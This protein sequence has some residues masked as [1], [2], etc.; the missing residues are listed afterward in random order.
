MTARNPPKETSPRP[1]SVLIVQRRLTEYRVALFERLK[2]LLAE[3]GLQLL[4]VHGTATHEE[5][6][7]GDAGVLPWAVRVP[8]V[9]LPLFGNRLSWLRIPGSIFQGQDLVIVTH[10]NGILS[11][12]LPFLRRSLGGPRVAWWG[13]G[14]KW[15]GAHSFGRE[16]LKGCSALIGDRY[17]AYTSASV[18]RVTAA[19]V[20][21]DRI[22]CL[23]NAVGIEQHPLPGDTAWA[24]DREQLKRELGLG[25]G[26]VGIYLGSLTREKRIDVLIDA[27]DELRLRHPTFQ[28]IIVGDGS[29]RKQVKMAQANR[30]WLHWLGVLHGRRKALACSLGHA[31]LNPGMVGLSIVDA[32][33]AGLPLVTMQH[34][35]HSPEIAYLEHGKNGLLAEDDLASFVAACERALTDESLRTALLEGCRAGALRY[36]VQRMADLFADGITATVGGHSGVS[37]QCFPRLTLAVVFRTFLPYHKARLRHL[38]ST[39]RAAGIRLLQIEVASQDS[40]YDFTET[41]LGDS[42]ERYCCFPGIDYQ[43]L[44]A[45]NVHGKVLEL[46][47]QL[48]PDAVIGHAVPFP[49]GMAAIA[50]RNRTGARVF[51]VDDAWSGSDLSGPIVRYVKRFIHANVDGALLPSKTHQD[52]YAELGLGPD[53]TAVGAAVVDNAF[54]DRNASAARANPVS[55]RARLGMPEHYFL[56]VGRFLERKGITYL[57]RAYGRYRANAERPWSLVLVG[58]SGL[59]LPEDACLQPGVMMPGRLFGDDLAMTIG[60]AGALVVPS[61]I[62]QWGL[63]VNEAMAAGTPVIVSRACGAAQLVEDGVSGYT[64]QSGDEVALAERLAQMSRSTEAERAALSSGAK[65]AVGHWG[66]DRFSAGVFELLQ[67]PRRLPAGLIARAVSRL[68]KGWVRAY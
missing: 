36:T 46:L 35:L 19:G 14:P 10:E 15:P 45:R 28:L 51:I 40:A 65:A 48:R 4:V 60:L 67:V 41:P 54:F 29:L 18:D 39:C 5:R 50:Y 42:G 22:T 8:T 11:N 38:D 32:F 17:F 47:E 25:Q 27:A 2:T 37:P 53:S 57:L 33:A 43:T 68:W 1:A 9:Y 7:R 16:W 21:P 3:R 23:D 58:G 55:T 12:V 20:P 30:A 34:D 63:V 56:F 49:E 52:Y 61:L 59:D 62:E 31:M 64:I 26:P 13:H 6:A 66:L 44:T 24:T